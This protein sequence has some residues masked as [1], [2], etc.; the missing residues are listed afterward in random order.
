MS[1]EPRRWASP[2]LAGVAVA[3]VAACGGDGHPPGRCGA[4][5]DTAGTARIASVEAAPAGEYNCTNDPVKVLLDFAPLDPARPDLAA[6][7]YPLTVGAGANPPSAWVT[8]SGLVVGSEHPAMR[9]DQPVG[10]CSPVVIELTDV[11]S[12]AGLAACF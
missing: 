3:L 2:S 10:P 1:A 12:S 4:Y 11:D 6:S 7:G 9:S 8:A 5:F